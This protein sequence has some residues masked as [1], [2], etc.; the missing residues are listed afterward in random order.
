MK[1]QTGKMLKKQVLLNL[2]VVIII[3]LLVNLGIQLKPAN[4]HTT[5]TSVK[6]EWTGLTSYAL[7][8]ENPEFTSPVK[9]QKSAELQLKPGTYYW[10]VPFMGKCISK[11]KFAIDSEVALDVKPALIGNETAYRIENKGNTR[12]LLNI[13]G[14]FT[15]KAVLEPNA[16]TYEKNASG[17]Q[18]ITASENE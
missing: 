12:I 13:I 8:D 2:A 3:I 1:N 17:I 4:M 10:C 6:F 15:G 9:V 14:I 11:Q 5:N 7:V 16:V 18:N